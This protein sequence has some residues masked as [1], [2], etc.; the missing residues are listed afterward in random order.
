MK[1][2]KKTKKA[3]ATENWYAIL[4]TTAGIISVLATRKEAIFERNVFWNGD[5][6]NKIVP[7]TITYALPSKKKKI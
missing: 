7:C 3:L 4:G 6:K 2:L 5:K 1:P